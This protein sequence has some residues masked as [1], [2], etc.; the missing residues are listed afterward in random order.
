MQNSGMYIPTL[1]DGMT[2]NEL[3]IRMAALHEEGYGE[4]AG[5]FEK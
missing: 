4:F 3:L 5:L 2:V 1:V